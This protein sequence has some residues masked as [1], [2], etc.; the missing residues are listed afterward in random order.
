MLVEVARFIRLPVG[1]Y[2]TSS[3]EPTA[4]SPTAVL[5]NCSVK[6]SV[7]ELVSGGVTHYSFDAATDGIC[8][9]YSSFDT[10]GK[11]EG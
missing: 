4:T 6:A 3:T 9:I 1:Y 5:K 10:I 8:A 11:V 2:V 7:E